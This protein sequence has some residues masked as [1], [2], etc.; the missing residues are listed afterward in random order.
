MVDFFGADIAEE[1][2]AAMKACVT[3]DMRYA[4]DMR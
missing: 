2:N 1:P 3:V 4:F